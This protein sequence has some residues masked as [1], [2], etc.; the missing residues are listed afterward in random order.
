MHP[1]T[2]TCNL[3]PFLQNLVPEFRVLH[4]NFEVRNKKQDKKISRIGIIS[5]MHRSASKR[6]LNNFHREYENVAIYKNTIV[7]LDIFI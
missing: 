3:L 1:N 5:I 2:L 7:K 6:Q 4:K